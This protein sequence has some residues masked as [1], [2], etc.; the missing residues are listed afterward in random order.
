MVRHVCDRV[1]VMYLGRIMEEGPT[2]AV[3]ASPA[4]PYT[5][6]LLSATPR[7]DPSRRT[8][9]ILLAGEPPSPAAPPSGCVFRT[10]CPHALPR[11]AE[12][13]PDLIEWSSRAR[14]ACLRLGEIA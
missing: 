14:V 9:R 3:F 10:R 8:R 2:E 6:A 7:L 12:V 4:H 11:C 5:R 1:I 13:V